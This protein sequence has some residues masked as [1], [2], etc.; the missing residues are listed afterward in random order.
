MGGM[1]AGLP[2]PCVTASRGLEGDEPAIAL[3]VLPFEDDCATL[4]ILLALCYP[5]AEGSDAMQGFMFVRKVY[6]ALTKYEMDSAMVLLRREWSQ[7]SETN[8][9]QAYL[10]AVQH[11][12][13]VEANKAEEQLL[14]SK[15]NMGEYYVA[16]M[17]TTS[18]TVYRA[19]LLKHRDSTRELSPLWRRLSRPGGAAAYT[20]P[21]M[22]HRKLY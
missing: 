21:G 8:S 11:E 5:V 22:I 17:E 7:L 15:R 2:P 18:A 20:T 4:R 13:G 19:F 3:P 6:D 12:A 14:A 10:L 9:L 1:V 16:A